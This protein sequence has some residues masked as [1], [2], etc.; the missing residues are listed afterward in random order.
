MKDLS[1]IRDYTQNIP[2]LPALADDNG[3]LGSL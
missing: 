2:Q 1:L 3:D